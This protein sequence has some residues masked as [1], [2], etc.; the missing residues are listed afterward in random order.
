MGADLDRLTL[1]AGFSI[2]IYSDQV[3]GAR[4]MALGPDGTLYVGTMGDKVY[5]LPDADHDHKPD[6]VVEILAKAGDKCKKAGG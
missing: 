4:S 1:P 2:E 6:R 3:P 5:A